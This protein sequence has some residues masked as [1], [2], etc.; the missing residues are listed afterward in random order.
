MTEQENS[1]KKIKR[2]IYGKP[3]SILVMFPAG[4]SSVAR[5]EA[6]YILGNLW[7]QNKFSSKIT[8]LKNALR[9]DQIHMFAVVELLMRGQCFSDIRLIVGEGKV[10]NMPAFEKKCN[11]IPWD[12]YV[13]PS[14]TI[15]IKID[16]GASPALHEGAMKEALVS[17][18][19]GKV[20]GIVAGEDA[21]ET[22]SLYVD[23][24]KYYSTISISLAGAPLYKRGYRSELS[25][26]APLREDIAACCIQK[27]LD[28]GVSK[29]EKFINHSLFVPFSGTGT[30][31]FEYL[32]ACYL[33]SPVL[34]E[35]AYAIQDMP[36]FR[37]DNFNY[38]IKKARE[39]CLLEKLA[40]ENIY[41]MDNAKSANDALLKNIENFKHAVEKNQSSWVESGTGGWVVLDDF[42]KMDIPASLAKLSGNIF[43]PIN[44][45]YGLRLG[46]SDNTVMLYKQIARQINKFIEQSKIRKTELLG[47]ILCPSEESW[48]GF[49][50]TLTNASVETYHIT[51]GGL[52]IRVLQFYYGAE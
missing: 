23:A 29:N 12:F 11:S 10:M 16:S 26:S 51:Q 27:A 42:L 33:F 9:I 32:I 22:T 20:S 49:C 50:K 28:F 3:Q 14:M 37:S 19:N 1:D 5:D 52:D 40:P 46:N 4:L 34:F 17:C 24:Y 44:P 35:R 31:L 39:N 47:F 48:S 36:L 18:L 41:C 13:S 7:F 30:F 15:K 45:P 25:K 6:R 43:I 2:N 38:L 21:E 8:V